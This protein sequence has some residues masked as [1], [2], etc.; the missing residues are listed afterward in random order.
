MTFD[1]EFD[2]IMSSSHVDYDHSSADEADDLVKRSLVKAS[3]R[4]APIE[5]IAEENIQTATVFVEIAPPP[6]R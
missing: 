4:R 2:S 3:N 6:S 1:D 5:D